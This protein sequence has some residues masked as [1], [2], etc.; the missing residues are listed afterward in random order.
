MAS[1]PDER[2]DLA[3]MVQVVGGFESDEVPDGLAPPCRMRS[4][5]CIP[6]SR[7]EGTE[8]SEVRET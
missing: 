7:W 4:I 5:A 2:P 3:K 1:G 6:R 8:E